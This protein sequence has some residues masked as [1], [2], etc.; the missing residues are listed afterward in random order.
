[1]AGV[2]NWKYAYKVFSKQKGLHQQQ[3]I[4]S[5]NISLRAYACKVGGD[6]GCMGA[7]C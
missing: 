3:A 7:G 4:Y 5:H 2:F 6:G 1:M